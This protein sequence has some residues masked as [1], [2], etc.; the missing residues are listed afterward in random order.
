MSVEIGATIENAV[1]NALENAQK[2]FIYR[3]FLHAVFF[4]ILTEI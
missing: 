4:L 2:T 1:G 3:S